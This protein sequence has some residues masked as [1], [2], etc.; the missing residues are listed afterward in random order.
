ML[1]ARIAAFL[2]GL[3]IVFSA[4]RSAIRTFVLPRSA[5]DRIAGIVYA[6]TRRVFDYQARRKKTYA[7]Q[8]RI[9]ALLSPIS[10]VAL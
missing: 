6:N 9:R 5:G 10:L 2:V 4:M 1:I 8:D 7:E 3:R